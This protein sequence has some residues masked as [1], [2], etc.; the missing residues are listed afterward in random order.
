MG[1]IPERVWQECHTRF[2]LATSCVVGRGRN[3]KKLKCWP[4]EMLIASNRFVRTMVGI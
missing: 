2:F 1:E 3:D 4:A